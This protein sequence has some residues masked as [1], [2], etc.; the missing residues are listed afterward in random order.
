MEM[1]YLILS[2]VLIIVGIVGIFVP[3]IPSVILVLV[4]IFLY[5]YKTNFAVVS[6]DYIILF[7]ILTVITIFLDYL[8]TLILAKKHHMSTSNIIGMFLSGLIGFMIL[9][10][11]GLIIGQ[12]IGIIVFELISGEGWIKSFKKGGV[13][14][15]GYFMSITIKVFVVALMISIFA[16]KV[17]F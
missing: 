17:I 1:S 12:A 10:V 4:G 16:F 11:V 15:L 13:S 14:F 5:A 3:T 6:M 8:T 7:S 9:N 2:I